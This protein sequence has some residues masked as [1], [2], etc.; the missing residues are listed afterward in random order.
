MACS[1][2]VSASIIDG[3]ASLSILQRA[4]AGYSPDRGQAKDAYNGTPWQKEAP[5]GHSCTMAQPPRLINDAH[6]VLPLSGIHARM[7]Q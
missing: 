5:A 2:L 7:P 6:H 3:F 4:A 1:G